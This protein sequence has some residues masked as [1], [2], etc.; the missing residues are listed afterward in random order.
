MRF[1]Q[2]RV[3]FVSINDADMSAS[4]RCPILMACTWP[5]SSALK[6]RSGSRWKIAIAA[7][8]RW[9]Q[10]S[11]LRRASRLRT[12]SRRAALW[13]SNDFQCTTRRISSRRSFDSECFQ[14]TPSQAD[15]LARYF[16]HLDCVQP[17]PELAANPASV[18][19]P[20]PATL[21]FLCQNRSHRGMPQRGQ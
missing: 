16:Q 6:L 20:R 12:R 4:L 18:K 21:S 8:C 5:S 1:G 14:S 15:Q 7:L 11:F 19:A 3:A 2:A 17:L 9:C 10:K 13:L